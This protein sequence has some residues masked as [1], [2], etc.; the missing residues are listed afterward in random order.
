MPHIQ[1]LLGLWKVTV[2][3]SSSHL[4]RILFLNQRVGIDIS[5]GR[6]FQYV[7][8]QTRGIENRICIDIFHGNQDT[9]LGI[10]PICHCIDIVRCQANSLIE[11]FINRIKDRFNRPLTISKEFKYFPFFI[12][13]A[14][15]CCNRFICIGG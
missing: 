12:A 3:D 5:N 6:G 8:I 7:K 15:R 9:G 10:D 1:F 14:N 11:E 2:G 13:E 4:T